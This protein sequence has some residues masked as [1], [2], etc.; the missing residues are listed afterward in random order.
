M[1]QWD[2]LDPRLQ[3]LRASVASYIFFNR[4]ECIAF[5]L[6]KDMVVTND[7]ITLRLREGKGKKGLRAGL[8]N[9]RQIACYDLP[10][11]G[12]L[13]RACF[14]GINTMGPPLTRRWALCREEDKK[15][16]DGIDNLNMVRCGIHYGMAL[17]PPGFAGRP[18]TYAKELPPLPTPSR[19][20]SPTS[21]TY[22]GTGP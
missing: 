5:C 15:T 17:P 2:P 4:G 19:F 3:L 9:T 18:T 11:A 21:A 13:L 12:H 6:A 22:A 1:V 14:A 20:P 10:R 7:H 16:M 8:R